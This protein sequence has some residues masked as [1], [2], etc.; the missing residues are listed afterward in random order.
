MTGNRARS[1]KANRTAS[2]L[3][4]RRVIAAVAVAVAVVVVTVVLVTM[5][6]ENG[7]VVATV[8]GERIMAADVAQMQTRCKFYYGENYTFEQAL[9]QLIVEAMVYQEAKQAGYLPDRE[10]AEEEL[11]AQLVRDGWTM[12]MLLAELEQHGI[13][14][15]DYLETFRREVAM[16]N[17]LDDQAAV[18]PEQARERYDRFVEIYGE[19]PPS[20]ESI[21]EQIVAVMERE[22]LTGL[23]ERLVAKATIERFIEEN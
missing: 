18:T 6:A 8:N 21:K 9:E 2:R 20:F 11:R 16:E 1:K 13:I 14:Y 4:N 17:F 22:N 23:M 19:D 5:G 15:D 10:Q 3:R 7:D 12:R